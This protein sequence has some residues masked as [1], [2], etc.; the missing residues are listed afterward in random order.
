MESLLRLSNLLLEG[1]RG[2]TDLRALE[3][4]LTN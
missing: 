4:Y 3:K 2:K 1:G